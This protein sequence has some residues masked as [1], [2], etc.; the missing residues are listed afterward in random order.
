MTR[1]KLSKV[2]HLAVALV[3]GNLALIALLGVVLPHSALPILSVVALT[4]PMLSAG[5]VEEAL[6]RE[7]RTAAKPR[8]PCFASR[9]HGHGVGHTL[10]SA[11]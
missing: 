11:A 5:A 9:G 4:L 10:H 8:V 7:P 2:R 3:L 6:R 1:N